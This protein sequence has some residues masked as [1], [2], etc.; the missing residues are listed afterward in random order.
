MKINEQN[1]F[2]SWSFSSYTSSPS[3]DLLIVGPTVVIS[4]GNKW[5]TWKLPVLDTSWAGRGLVELRAGCGLKNASNMSPTCESPPALLFR[6]IPLGIN[7]SLLWWELFGVTSSFSSSGGRGILVGVTSVDTDIPPII[8]V[9][10]MGV[11]KIEWGDLDGI[12]GP[13]PD[14]G[15]WGLAE[16]TIEWAAELSGERS[17]SSALL[18]VRPV[19]WV[20]LLV[21]D[22]TSSTVVLAVVAI[23]G[24]MPLLLNRSEYDYKW[25]K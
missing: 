18:P 23:T 5:S 1:M 7:E 13:A 3:P 4:L 9:V 2:T 11:C 6:S 25:D 12:V 22:R 14:V 15:E 17:R 16:I 19:T 10:C 24:E 8:L 21:L 20:K